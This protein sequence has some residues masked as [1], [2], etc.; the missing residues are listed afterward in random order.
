[1]KTIV[2]SE[3]DEINSILDGVARRSDRNTRWES[4]ADGHLGVSLGYLST[5]LKYSY[6]M[7]F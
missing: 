6:V 5:I 7:V 2:S 4:R 1:M 3:A